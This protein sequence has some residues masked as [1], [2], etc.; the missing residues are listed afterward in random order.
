MVLVGFAENQFEVCPSFLVHWLLAPVFAFISK[1]LRLV[2]D[3]V[4]DF[5]KLIGC[6]RCVAGVG[7]HHAVLNLFYEGFERER[8]IKGLFHLHDPICRIYNA[9]GGGSVS[10]IHRRI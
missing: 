2:H 4:G 5:Y 6:E 3:G 7:Y 8:R 1:N 9:D 10:L